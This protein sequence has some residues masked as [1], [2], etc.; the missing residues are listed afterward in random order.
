[1]IEKWDHMNC[2]KH[3]ILCGRLSFFILT[4]IVI[5]ISSLWAAAPEFT[6]VPD[7]SAVINSDWS[8]AFKA[9]DVDGDGL[10]Y[11]T[12][13]VLPS[14]LTMNMESV[15][16]IDLG[17]T[18]SNTPTGIAIDSDG[19]QFVVCLDG[20][21]IKKIT[22]DGTVTIYSGDG[23][24]NRVDGHISEAQFNGPIDIAID[25]NDNLFVADYYNHAIRMITPDGIVSTIAGGGAGGI[26]YRDSGN[27]VGNGLE[28]RFLR[29]TCIAVDS[30]NNLF[31][32]DYYNHCI[33]K[34]E[35][36]E[37]SDVNV[38]YVVGSTTGVGG[39][40]DGVG[41]DARLNKPV[42]IA[43]DNFDNLYISEKDNHAVRKITNIAGNYNVV[44]I[45]GGNGPGS[46]MNQFNYPRGVAVDPLGENVYVGDLKN[47]RIQRI[48][49]S[50]NNYIVSTLI[51]DGVAANTV[52]TGV[53][54]SISSPSGFEVINAS[55]FYVATR[56]GQ[57]IRKVVL[58]QSP[59][60]SGT[61]DAIG[62]FPTT[63]RVSDGTNN[64]DQSFTISVKGIEQTITFNELSDVTYGDD[65][66]SLSAVSS[67]GLT[68]DYLSSNEDI[69][70][71][72]GNNITINGAGNVTIIATQDGD[73]TYSPALSI[74]RVLR[75]NKKSVSIINIAANDKV[76]D[77]TTDVILGNGQLSGVINGDDVGIV[78]GTAQFA[79]KNVGNNKNVNSSGYTINGDDFWKYTL[80]VQPTISMAD[81]TPK[82]ISVTSMT[83]S[84]KQ[85]DGNIIAN[86]SSSEIA[87]VVNGDDVFLSYT[88][89]NF[90]NKSVGENKVVTVS[91]CL[92]SG[93]ESDNYSLTSDEF[94]GN[95]NITAKPI[96][97]TGIIGSDKIYD[98]SITA[99]YTGISSLVGLIEN[100][101]VDLTNG[102]VVFTDRNVGTAIE[103]TASGFSISGNDALNYTLLQPDG[104]T[105]NI[106]AKAV[107]INNVSVNTKVYDGTVDATLSG[108]S[109]SGVI[110]GDDVS[111]VQGLGSFDNKK[112]GTNKMVTAS[113]F[114]IDG[115]ASSNYTLSSQPLVENGV[116]NPK[117][118]TITNIL[119]QNK[120][121]DGTT[122]ASIAS[123][124]ITGIILNDDVSAIYNTT[125]FENKDAGANK[126]VTLTDYSISGVDAD[127]YSLVV[128]PLTTSAS[129]TPKVI[130]VSGLSAED[131]N[132][133]GTVSATI[134][135]E[136]VLSGVVSGDGVT[137]VS[138][139][140]TFEDKNVGEDKSITVTGSTLA[141]SDAQNYT[142]GEYVNLVAD[143]NPKSISIAS[144]SVDNK[145]YDGSR[146]AVI[147]DYEITGLIN[148]DIVSLDNMTALFENKNVGND[149]K[150]DIVVGDITG[151][152]S[153]N[154]KLEQITAVSTANISIRNVSL[155]GLNALSKV[156]DG[157]TSSILSGI[158]SI[159]SVVSGDNV[160][161][162]VGTAAFDNKNVGNDK[163][164]FITG[165]VLSGSDAQ[166]YNLM[167]PCTLSSN[168][169]PLTTTISGF[170][171]LDKEY[172]G[173][174]VVTVIGG[175]VDNKIAGDSVEVL[176]D[177]AFFEDKNVGKRK[178]I[179]ASGFNISGLDGA[180]YSI[181]ESPIVKGADIT[182]K[183]VTVSNIAVMNKVYDGLV[184]AEIYGGTLNGI[185]AGD[186][187][188]LVRGSATFANKDV[189][190]G[191]VVTASDFAIS[192]TESG[193]YVLSSQ[194]VVNSASITPAKLIITADDKI[195]TVGDNDPLFTVT[196]EGFVPGEDSSIVAGLIVEREVGEEYGEYY[197]TPSGA[198]AINYDI[199]FYEGILT[200]DE[201]SDI[202]VGEKLPYLSKEMG[203]VPIV[204]PL[205]LNSES[206]EFLVLLDQSATVDVTV[207]DMLGNVLDKQKIASRQ[208]S[209]RYYKWNMRNQN[210]VKVAPGT[211]VIVAKVEYDNG[212]IG[213]QK[214]TIGLK[215]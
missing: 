112:V 65:S 77:G 140:G 202:T 59:V 136:A 1:M 67:S 17:V 135:G 194:P 190:N 55:T 90:D 92:L 193:C 111:I 93:D 151:A 118:I 72:S 214:R 73:A 147:S 84:N 159:K 60:L 113:G 209:G 210:G 3:S 32:T 148:N 110:I 164:V 126:V 89:A 52:G 141:G 69:A 106:T 186:D 104:L 94:V 4:I 109:L 166:N 175:V 131:K 87:N 8:Y 199:D 103:L 187:V 124:E 120:V 145:L 138:G 198:V 99:S 53:N 12:V 102:A 100:D 33:K 85:Y 165:S 31:V 20:H 158:P 43:I 46:A 114:A 48:A 25:D 167:E 211:Y 181:V 62:E 74:E 182:P 180:N 78:N 50:G 96:N 23:T 123:G 146:S 170:Q 79:D 172:D 16:S 184:D 134:S 163:I 192:G 2:I 82:P 115:A 185:F 44:T 86:I 13:G 162:T 178:N 51:G 11:S 107:T 171:G 196:Y 14:W 155:E 188:T 191:I 161:V 39:S 30:D 58:E 38:T 37:N 152:E 91:G 95:A 21:V 215:K 35:R 144:V 206:F 10:S 150:I 105:A 122:E 6:T 24:Q 9:E 41:T 213:F 40:D 157:S 142:V 203:I 88:T 83:I 195:K 200:I 197:I 133:D 49:I 205:S 201:I 80:D 127:N 34:I 47:Y 189:A 173:T 139:V 28:T 66:F 70:S 97:I 153:Q 179:I 119:A 174:N 168:I 125:I 5:N 18:I 137:Y 169:T 212:A 149:K 54:A 128:Q 22:P 19:N 204:N 108:G 130:S 71:I 116:V 26:N 177:T 63:V 208:D 132:Y 7:T 129:I 143:I 154:Y 75:V 121:Y 81:I 160:L 57:S 45:A 36:L 68:V 183:Q 176:I 27:A 56:Q 101:V 117:P 61:P 207:C 42:S 156:Y 15:G 76:Y 98:G 29:P 64:V